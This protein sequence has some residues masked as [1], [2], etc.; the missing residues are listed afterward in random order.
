[1]RCRGLAKTNARVMREGMVVTVEPGVYIEKLGGIRI[2]DEM[3]VTVDRR[4]QS[5]D[6]AARISRTLNAK[7]AESRAGWRRPRS[8]IW[9]K[10]NAC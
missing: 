7:K 4:D 8:W 9:R 2:E 1:M 3:L 10:S 6:S 5:H